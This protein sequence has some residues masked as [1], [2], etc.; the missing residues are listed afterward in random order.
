M[1]GQCFKKVSLGPQMLSATLL[2]VVEPL[3]TSTN[4]SLSGIC[5]IGSTGVPVSVFVPDGPEQSPD[6]DVNYAHR[7]FSISYTGAIITNFVKIIHVPFHS[8]PSN[9]A[10]SS[11]KRD[12]YFQA[13]KKIGINKH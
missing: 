2:K 3:L 6:P 11:F 1:E 7:G 9:Q 10:S 8:T 4:V 13:F 5:G 12:F